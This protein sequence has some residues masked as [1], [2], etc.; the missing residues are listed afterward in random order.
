M[1]FHDDKLWQDAFTALLDVL[2][3]TDGDSGDLVEQVRK[4]AMMTLT[5]VAQGVANRDR[6]F[7]DIK[8]RSVGTGV[9]VALRSLLSV[10]WAREMLSDDEFAKL[11]SAYESL[12]NKLPR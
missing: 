10:M 7:R 12:S 6:K 4:H 11:D 5:E 2:E 3:V 1:T 8:L 9:I